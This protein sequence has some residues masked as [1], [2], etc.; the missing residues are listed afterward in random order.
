MGELE[1]AHLVGSE[2]R[3]HGVIVCF[4]IFVSHLLA[5]P[6]MIDL[7]F[8]FVLDRTRSLAGRILGQSGQAKPSSVCICVLAA[9]MIDVAG[10][11]PLGLFVA[12]ELA[13]MPNCQ[14][15]QRARTAELS[16]VDRTSIARSC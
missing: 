10:A 13:A 2:E 4:A 11:G 8:F 6:M 1:A 15:K 7:L 3:D 12:Q 14:V 9:P 5:A 16:K